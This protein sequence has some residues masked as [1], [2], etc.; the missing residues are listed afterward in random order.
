MTLLSLSQLV[1][2]EGVAPSICGHLDQQPTETETLTPPFQGT[3]PLRCLTTIS[4]PVS[5]LPAPAVLGCMSLL[6]D[7]QYIFRVQ[8]KIV[9]WRPTETPLVFTEVWP[10][11][12]AR[13]MCGV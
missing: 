7:H 11:A 3:L 4:G 6:I 2:E 5:R 13:P 1:A 10:A 9:F 12:V 8:V